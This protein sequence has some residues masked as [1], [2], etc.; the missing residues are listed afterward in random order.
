MRV[1]LYLG[2]DEHGVYGCMPI[3][4]YEASDG[5]FF[6]FWTGNG[7]IHHDV[8][9][10][11]FELNHK[12]FM[13][14]YGI[15]VLGEIAATGHMTYYAHCLQSCRTTMGGQYL[16]EE[17]IIGDTFAMLEE[18][19]LDNYTRYGK[20]LF[21]KIPDQPKGDGYIETIVEMYM[22]KLVQLSWKNDSYRRSVQPWKIRNALRWG[23]YQARRR[24]PD[25]G[26]NQR[27][28][29]GFITF[30]DEFC[31]KHSAQELSYYYDR[32]IFDTHLE[33]GELVWNAWFREKFE[34]KM[35]RYNNLKTYEN[36]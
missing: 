17:A 3:D 19:C 36:A 31:E 10:H 9:E 4:C 23:Y 26:H 25:T 7:G 34:R 32:L 16:M 14:D 2:E 13:G 30:W 21:C 35:E 29:S 20:E 24:C 33:Q 12:Y 28:M 5:G 27:I 8:F 1:T 18:N 11:Y 6:G 22:E 15:N